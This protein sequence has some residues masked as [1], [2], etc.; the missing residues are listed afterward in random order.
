MTVNCPA[1]GY[2]QNPADSEYCEA[3]G[4]EMP[5]STATQNLASVAPLPLPLS[6]P[7]TPTT[8]SLPAISQPTA[9][10]VATTTLPVTSSVASTGRLI[11]KTPNSPVSEFPLDGSSAI[12]GKFDQ[13]PVEIDLENFAGSETVSRAHAE[14]YQEAGQWKVKDLGSSNGTFLKRLG[15]SRFGSGITTTEILNSGDEIAFG[16]V[17]FL[18]QSP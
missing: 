16:K 7:I 6:A 5:K 10:S 18:F 14:I 2:D 13:V 3:C 8:S 17:R 4:S 15:Q 1:C 9:P 12:V 11:A